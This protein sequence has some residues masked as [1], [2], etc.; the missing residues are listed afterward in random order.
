MKFIDLFAGIGG[1][2]LALHRLGLE[3][4]FASE[5]DKHARK[6]YEANFSSISLELFSKDNFN[7]DITNLDFDT[8]PD[9]DLLCAG[10][11]C[12]SFSIAG[13]GAGFS[14]S[15][16]LMFFHLIDIIRT[17][18]PKVIFLENVRGLLS[19]D[20]GKTFRF[21]KGEL[22]AAGY[23]IYHKIIKACDHGLPQLRPRL[24]IIGIDKTIDKEKAFTFPDQ[25][26]LKYTMSDIFNGV[27]NRDIGF[28]IRIGGNGSKINDRRNWQHYLVDGEIRKI[29]INEV[30]KMMGYQDDFIFPVSH[31][32]IMKQ[33]GN[34]VAIDTISAIGT[35]LIK[36]IKS[37]KGYI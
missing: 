32:Q 16:G 22:E 24:Y 36:Y 19:H 28:S 15:R 13:N 11:P 23:N 6:T 9:F 7:E 37:I 1:F 29:G 4:V 18:M 34:S 25:I 27:C 8:I 3:C 31:T 17:K 30:K 33:L 5:I 10:F 12:Q 2:H 21:M 20:K 26:P 14:D 35:S